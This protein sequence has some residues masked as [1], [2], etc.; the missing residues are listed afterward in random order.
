MIFVYQVYRHR[1]IISESCYGRVL[2]PIVGAVEINDLYL[3]EIRV[4]TSWCLR[5]FL[6]AV[7]NVLPR[8][9]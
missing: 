6:A 8:V 7:A 4:F 3:E 9:M 1:K 5:P 2:D